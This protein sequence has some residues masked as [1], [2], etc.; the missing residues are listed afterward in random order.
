MKL[1]LRSF[2]YYVYLFLSAT[3]LTVVS[4]LSA[5]LPWRRRLPIARLWC[6]GMLWA[7]RFICD[8]DYVVEGRENIPSTPSVIM[9]KHTSI[10]EAFIQVVEFPPQCWVVKRELLWIPIFGWGLA[11]MKPIAINREAGR[12][13]VTQV[14][15]KGRE[16]LA[17]GIWVTIFPEGTRVEPGSTKKYGVSGAALA[18][19]AGVPI[20]PVAHNACDFWPRR[21]FLKVPGRMRFCIGPPI[22]AGG[23]KP[24]DTNVIVQGWVENKMAEISAAYRAGASGSAAGVERTT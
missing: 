15:E 17:E 1:W 3:G 20:V 12:V 21:S 10:I 24:K 9:V 4:M 7:G 6:R 22:D 8:F 13:A 16:R 2:A 14:I 23:R 19:S 11:P 5:P 18:Q